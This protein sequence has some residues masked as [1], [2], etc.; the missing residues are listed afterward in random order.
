MHSMENTESGA[1][2]KMILALAVTAFALSVSAALRAL[3]PTPQSQ[4][5]ASWWMKRHQQKCV[6]ATN[7][8][9]RLVFIGDSITHG[10]ESSG[11]KAWE[12]YFA[13]APYHALN[14]GFGADRT[15]HVI[16]RLTTGGELDGYEAKVIVLMIGTNNTGHFKRPDEM[17]ID[18]IAGVSR[19]LE[20]I[21]QK[22]PKARTILTAIFPRG[23]EDRGE[24]CAARNQVV[25]KELAALADGRK[26]I[27]CDFSDKFLSPDGRISREIF[28]DL[29]HPN[30]TGYEIWSSALLPVLRRCWNA[31]PEECV[32]SVWPSNPRAYVTGDVSSA[33]LPVARTGYVSKHRSGRWWL[34]R[35]VSRRNRIADAAGEFDLVM[36]GDSITHFWEESA[37]GQGEDTWAALNKRYRVLNLGYG[38]DR[39]GNVLWRLDNGE[40]DGYRAKCITLMI[41]TNNRNKPEEIVAGIRAILAKLREKQPQAKVLL[42]KIFPRG[43]DAKDSYRQNNERVN[44]QL[45]ALA[46][47]ERVELVDIN[48]QLVDEKGDSRHSMVYDRLHPSTK[49]Y[50]VWYDALIPRL[51]RICGK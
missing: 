30:A 45:A 38:G 27:W 41:G 3:T 17:P 33:C 48:A 6:E 14:L 37:S 28:P 18:T 35:L 20:I 11:A 51:E 31:Q 1:D 22:Q 21:A 12:K 50:Q 32:E 29:L 43:K 4:D 23:N 25:N 16:W 5:P 26:V 39:T 42:F 2:M 7:V 44:A 47:G 10:W 9:S 40:G 46:D 13:G 34:N 24:S 49:G 36:I 15:E 19:I 8:A